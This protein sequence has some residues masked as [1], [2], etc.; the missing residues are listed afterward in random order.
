MKIKHYII[1][2]VILSLVGTTSMQAEP[3]KSPESDIKAAATKNEGFSLVP[4]YPNS[5]KPQEFLFELKPGSKEEEYVYVKNFSDEAT[6]FLLYGADTTL[7]SQGT[8][9]YKTRDTMGE[10]QGNWIQFEHPEIRLN[11]GEGKREKFTMTVPDKTAM[12][13]Y[14][15]GIAIEKSKKDSKNPNITIATRV[16][17]KGEVKVT[18]DPKPIPKKT[19]PPTFLKSGWQTWYF[20]ISLILF[21]ISL[22]VF[23]W[24]AMKDKKKSPPEKSE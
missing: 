23:I 3:L 19:A 11:P 13:T 21:L 17:L 5:I 20:W 6:T 12:G 9:A 16:I 8:R 7:S 2:G 10:G 15:L 14:F 18:N 4:A 1:I 22:S 24:A